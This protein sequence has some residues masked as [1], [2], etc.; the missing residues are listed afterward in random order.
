VGVTV[1]VGV[2]VGVFETVFV[3]V[4]VGVTVGVELGVLGGVEAGVEL[5]VV[6][7]VEL[8]L[9]G[10]VEGGLLVAVRV[11]VGLGLLAGG[12]MSFG[13]G[14]GCPNNQV[15]GLNA[16][17]PTAAALLAGE[18]DQ[19][20]F[21]VTPMAPAVAVAEATCEVPEFTVALSTDFG[22]A[23]ATPRTVALPSP[24]ASVSA[25]TVVST[26]GAVRP[27][28]ATALSIGAVG[29]MPR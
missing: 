5:G 25:A 6:G 4:G 18:V 1:G 29:E 9:L 17:T 19:V 3:G 10:G 23:A 15:P 8:G 26:D 24:R 7:G 14:T 16:S 27:A 13:A 22:G 12:T 20:Y 11:G 2:G 21:A 28:I